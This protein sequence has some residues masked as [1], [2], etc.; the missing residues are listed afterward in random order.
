[1]LLFRSEEHARVWRER[2]ALPGE[3]LTVGGQWELARR[4]Y[5]GR[6]EFGWSPAQCAGVTGHPRVRRTD[7][8]LLVP[9][10]TQR[11]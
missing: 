10:L 1:M 2:R 9:R 11:Y 5:A 8:P 3:M 6:L 7:R 4:W